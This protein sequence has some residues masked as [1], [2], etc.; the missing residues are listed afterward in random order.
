MLNLIWLALLVAG[1]AAAAYNGDIG[2]VTRTALSAS[3]EAVEICFGLAGVMALW[4]G[5]MRIMER[6]GFVRRLGRFMT[7]L[8][9]RLYPDIPPHHPAMGAIIMNLSANML[10]LGNAA[11]P[12][13][14]KAM[15]ELQKLNP[16]RE[17][18]TDAMCTFLAMNTSC[19][20]LIPATII[21][22]RLSFDSA[23]PTAVVGPC[24]LA[25]CC[26]MTVAMTLDA[27]LRKVRR[28]ARGC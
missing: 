28:R 1:I 17:T 25:T 19:V 6:A 18:A 24:V 8:L 9:R 2:V 14:M 4:L 26:A 7:P 21:G 3:Q 23:D 11:T 10:G 20:T 27:V 12:F 5:I 15:Q 13:G 22:V 16:D